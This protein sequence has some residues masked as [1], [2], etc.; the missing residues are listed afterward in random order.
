M[1]P[2]IR[3]PARLAGLLMVVSCAT[4][5]RGTGVRPAAMNSLDPVATAT[6][7]SESG[8][9]DSLLQALRRFRPLFLKSRGSTP[10]I[11]IDGA[12]VMDISFLGTLRVSAIVEVR[13]MRAPSLYSG[14]RDVLFVRTTSALKPYPR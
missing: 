3:W 14:D 13:L 5:S 8:R 2:N 1:P 7:I 6:D 9:D 12:P 11:T 10:V 4:G